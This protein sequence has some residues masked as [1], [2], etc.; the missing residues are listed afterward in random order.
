MP[1]ETFNITYLYCPVSKNYV[2]RFRF[3][4]NLLVLIS[5]FF[6]L[7]FFFN[8]KL[9]AS[10]DSNHYCTGFES[11]ASANWATGA[12]LFFYKMF[13]FVNDS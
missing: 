9:C 12:F 5:F 7:M 1:L 13:L 10:M 6:S 8:L 2:F 11:V 3:M 4:S